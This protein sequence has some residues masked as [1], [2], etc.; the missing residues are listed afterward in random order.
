MKRPITKERWQSMINAQEYTLAVLT[1]EN[2]DQDA[3]DAADAVL[4]FLEQQ[5]RT[6]KSGIIQQTEEQQPIT[7][8]RITITEHPNA[9]RLEIAQVGD[10]MCIVGKGDFVSDEIAAYIPEGSVLPSDVI[11]EMGLTGRLAGKDKNRVKAI[12]LRKILSQGLIYPTTGDKLKDISPADIREGVDVTESMGITKYVAPI[13]PKMAGQVDHSNKT[14]FNYNIEN[15]KKYPRTIEENE[16]IQITE[17][18]HGT[19]C[20]MG[21]HPD[22]GWIVSSKGLSGKGIYFKLDEGINDENVYVRTFRSLKETLEHFKKAMDLTDKDEWYIL[23]EVFGSGVQD[24][25]YGIKEGELGFRVF[26]YWCNQKW[27]NKTLWN[28]VSRWFDTV[29]ELYRGPASKEIIL[30]HTT[31]NSTLY[32]GHI[33]EGCVIRPVINRR[34]QSG[35]VIFKSISPDYLLRKGGTEH[36]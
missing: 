13:P 29:P 16:E 24:L 22:F 11:E 15:I 32:D 9:D 33:R 5:F 35:R 34:T 7:L 26:D 18:I 21:W 20:R 31:G 1:A 12:K 36:N 3:I 23:G 28:H 14:R 25:G 4:S 17:K 30:E 19:W 6:A 27:Q 8:E 10:F 2:K